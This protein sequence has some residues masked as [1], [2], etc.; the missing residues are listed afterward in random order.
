MPNS[1]AV[2]CQG[3][4]PVYALDKDVYRSSMSDFCS[5]LNAASVILNTGTPKATAVYTMPPPTTTGV[6]QSSS[7]ELAVVWKGNVGTDVLD[8]ARGTSCEQA[9]GDMIDQCEDGEDS[10]AVDAAANFLGC[11]FTLVFFEDSEGPPL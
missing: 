11:Y 4:A 9:F 5:K 6:F 2:T 3:N 10:K 8:L 1:P 7:F